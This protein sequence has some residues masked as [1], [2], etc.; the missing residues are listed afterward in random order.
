[1]CD[2]PDDPVARSRIEERMPRRLVFGVL[3]LLLPSIASAEPTAYAE[4]AKIIA[5]GKQVR[6][7]GLPTKSNA[8]TFKYF[9]V[10]VDLGIGGAGKPNA[11]AAVTAA[12]TDVQPSPLMF[13]TGTYANTE[14]SCEV[15]V[16]DA[17]GG[18]HVVTLNCDELTGDDGV[19]LVV[20]TGAI[21]GH[22]FENTLVANGID[23]LP[24]QGNAAW[25]RMESERGNGVDCFVGEGELLSALQ[26]GD[27]LVLSNY[28]NGNAL[29]CGAVLVRV[30]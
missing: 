5:E 21:A 17:A 26:I 18:R 7:F 9:D 14:F 30:P 15:T 3:I 25:G 24:G 23:Q 11:K 28:R 22:P 4:R 12:P 27:T 10:T 29:S 6:I 1:M 16:A 19:G 2:F 20:Y 8:G 13:A